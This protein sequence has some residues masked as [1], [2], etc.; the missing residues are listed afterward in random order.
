[1]RADLKV[2]LDACVLIPMPLADTLLRL[3]GQRRL[4]QPKWTDQIMTE[5]NRNLSENFGLTNEQVGYRESEIR[6][7]F[8][9]AWVVG[10]EELIS[11][12]SNHPKDRHVVAAAVRCNAEVIVTLNGKDF[13]GTALEPYSITVMG[14]STFLRNLYEL[15]PKFVAD[16]LE[17]QATSISR[18]VEYVLERLSINAPGFVSF[19]KTKG[20]QK[21][22]GREQ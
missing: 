22:E 5:V 12:M 11:A 10:H 13:P 19:F 3:A 16:T 1:V 18:T 21:P 14:P 20:L 9:E 15:D 2:V 6:R 7:H 17:R 4:Y 8:P